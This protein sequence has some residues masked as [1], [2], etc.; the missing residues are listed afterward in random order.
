MAATPFP[1]HVLLEN[2][3]YWH[4]NHI[5]FTDNWYTSFQVAQ[6]CTQRG[7]HVVG[8]IK[9]NRKGIPPIKLPG[10]HRTPKMVRGESVNKKTTF[11]GRDIYYTLWQDKKPVRILHSI[12]TYRGHCKRQV[13]D[14]RTNAWGR[15]Q[16][17]RPTVVPKYNGSMG[18]TDTSDQLG[19]TYRP[20]LKTKSWIPKVFSHFLNHGVR[21]SNVHTQRTEST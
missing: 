16:Y 21:H 3:K 8:T 7:I 15:R 5:L 2:E 11:G 6:I 17:R 13:K 4:R 9:A 18:G 1:I 12:K 20:R 14:S 10:Q 19:Q